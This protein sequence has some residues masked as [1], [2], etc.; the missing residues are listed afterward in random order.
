MQWIIV[1][2]L[3]LAHHKSAHKVTR[4]ILFSYRGILSVDLLQ[5]DVSVDESEESSRRPPAAPENP[6]A[7]SH[8]TASVLILN[9][10]GRSQAGGQDDQVV[11][12]GGDITLRR[13]G[14][15]S[16]HRW[17]ERAQTTRHALCPSR[18]C[19]ETF[20]LQEID[21]RAPYL[22]TITHWAGDTRQE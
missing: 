21:S 17:S 1:V 20:L 4:E 15:L 13:G 11:E 6:D 8:N 14:A 18:G 9:N 3:L 5:D 16:R 7:L 22:L 12:P 10:S 19:S 2:A